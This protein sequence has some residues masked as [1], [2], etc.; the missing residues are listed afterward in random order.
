MKKLKYKFW[1]LIFDVTRFISNLNHTVMMKSMSECTNLLPE[2]TKG[3]KKNG[4]KKV[5][6]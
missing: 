1:L 4:R 2:P 6:R 3:T 5:R